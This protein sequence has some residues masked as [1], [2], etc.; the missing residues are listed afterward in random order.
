MTLPTDDARATHA[1]TFINMA[2]PNT[3]GVKAPAVLDTGAK[4][5]ELSAHLASTLGLYSRQDKVNGPR[6]E[7]T[8]GSYA[9]YSVAIGIHGKKCELQGVKC[10]IPDSHVQTLE[11]VVFP[12]DSRKQYN[13][14][15][16]IGRETMKKLGLIL[17]F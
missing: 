14:D 8:N 13:I 4:H 9:T 10:K 7:T 15:A 16:I 11:Q 17:K 2:V 3:N 12:Q 1:F 6:I 5:T